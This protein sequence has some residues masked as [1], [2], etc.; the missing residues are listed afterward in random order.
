MSER[1]PHWAPRKALVRFGASIVATLL[2]LLIA[3]YEVGGG[4]ARDE[5]LSAD[6][7]FL[8]ALDRD[9]R[10]LHAWRMREDGRLEG[11]AST[12]GLP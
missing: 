6:W 3:A 7:R 9:G 10:R 2:V 1:R 12:D 5:A 8:Y 11:A 4:L